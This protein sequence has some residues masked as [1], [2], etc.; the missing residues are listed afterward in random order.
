M[1]NEYSFDINNYSSTLEE[2]ENVLHSVELNEENGISFIFSIIKLVDT[3][4]NA[5]WATRMLQ[6]RNYKR[7]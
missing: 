7:S 1:K 6:R 5:I 2:F 3:Q 4:Q